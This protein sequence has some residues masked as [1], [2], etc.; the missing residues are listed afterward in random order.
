VPKGEDEGPE[1]V[2][3]LP[4]SE[5]FAAAL[6]AVS[7]DGA[8]I[9]VLLFAGCSELAPALRPEKRPPPL[10]AGVPD[11]CPKS[12]IMEGRSAVWVQEATPTELF[13]PAG[14]IASKT[15]R[16]V[17]SLVGTCRAEN[18]CLSR[19]LGAPAWPCNQVIYNGDKTS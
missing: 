7:P 14:K 17:G 1:V 19:R 13:A 10:E 6:W 15:F 8:K 9:L 2:V 3:V 5:L 11:G 4:N 18:D 12:D 16:R